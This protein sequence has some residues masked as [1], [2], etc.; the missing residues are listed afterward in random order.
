M[1][2]HDTTKTN[3]ARP[4]FGP[5]GDDENP[6]AHGGCSFEELCLSCGAVRTVNANGVHR[7][8][9]RWD[10]GLDRLRKAL[11]GA[12][13][14]IPQKPGPVNIGDG[15]IVSVDDDWMLRVRV[16]GDNW[17]VAEVER[18]LAR[19][20]PHGWLVFVERGHQAWNTAEAFRRELQ[21]REYQ[22]G[23]TP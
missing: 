3:D 8:T 16:E 13:A 23:R 18:K 5:V 22:M 10:G 17:T 11:R 12:E 14:H 15:I 9:G 2:E 4:F 21:D 19:K 7:E 6:A 20:L 1:C